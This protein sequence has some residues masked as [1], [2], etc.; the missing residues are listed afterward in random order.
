MTFDEKYIWCAVHEMLRFLADRL[1]LYF[2]SDEG[3]VKRYVKDYF[4]MLD[5]PNPI[6]ELE[7]AYFKD[8]PNIRSWFIPNELAPTISKYNTDEKENIIGWIKNSPS[9]EFNSWIL[10]QENYIKDVDDSLS[11]DWICIHNF[12]Q[13]NE[14]LTKVESLLWID[15][16]LINKDKYNLF[17]K[18]L[19]SNEKILVDI[20][21]KEHNA[22]FSSPNTDT[23]IDASS[24]CWMPWI[25][26]I[27]AQCTVDSKNG[28]YKILKCL[29]QITST[30]SSGEE[31]E[32]IVQSKLMRNIMKIDE[33]NDWKYYN[34][35]KEIELFYSCVNTQF[36]ETQTLLYAKTKDIKD[37]IEENN[38][39]MFWCVRILRRPSLKTMDKHKKFFFEKDNFSIVCEEDDKL[40]TYKIH[41]Y[42]S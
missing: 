41:K 12:T 15:S 9:P 18:N 17:K 3:E 33:F 19:E 32:S 7:E 36:R 22:C 2:Y 25:E 21:T 1:P 5:I 14:Q 34:E 26:D 31:V 35:D 37:K 4:L 38:L 11:D 30:N 42:S 8:L 13:I 24:L 29:S 40:E 23:Y 20:F 39:K 6:Q 10:A 27:Y 28:N 16:Y